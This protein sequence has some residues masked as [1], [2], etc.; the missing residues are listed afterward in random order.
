MQIEKMAEPLLALPQDVEVCGK[1]S[2]KSF[3]IMGIVEENSKL[4][5]L[6]PCPIPSRQFGMNASISQE[7]YPS[8]KESG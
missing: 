2:S 4:S 5:L 3:W 1:S 8:H 7:T 6:F